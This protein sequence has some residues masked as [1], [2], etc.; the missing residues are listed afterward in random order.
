MTIEQTVEVPANRQIILEVPPEIAES[1]VRV[2]V[3]PVAERPSVMPLLL[4]RGSCKGSD[5]MEAYFQRKRGD[6]MLEN[7]NDR[8]GNG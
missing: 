2:S 8:Q 6:K 7:R 1:R 3:T 5:T 4:L